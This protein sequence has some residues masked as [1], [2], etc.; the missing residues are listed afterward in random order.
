MGTVSTFK[1]KGEEVKARILCRRDQ[2]LT[3]LI[4]API[5]KKMKFEKVNSFLRFAVVEPK[6]GDAKKKEEETTSADQ[7]EKKDEKGEAEENE[8]DDLETEIKTY[9]LK[10]TRDKSKIDVLLKAVEDIQQEIR[11]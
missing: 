7:K 9:L 2:I 11:Q 8:D 4:N 5:L 1:A 10:A 6:T 3:N